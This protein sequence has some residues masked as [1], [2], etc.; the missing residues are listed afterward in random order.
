MNKK[1]V[2]CW[3]RFFQVGAID[4][5][6]EAMRHMPDSSIVQRQAAILTRNMVVR[7]TELRPVFLDKGKMCMCQKTEHAGIVLVLGKCYPARIA[8]AHACQSC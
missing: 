7:N 5:V 8:L 3:F 4:W 6:L 2:E 1:T